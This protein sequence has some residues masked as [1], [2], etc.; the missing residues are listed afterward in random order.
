[1]PAEQASLLESTARHKEMR[2]D[3]EQKEQ[4]SQRARSERLKREAR[5]AGEQVCF[6]FSNTQGCMRKQCESGCAC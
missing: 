2:K 1:M 6:T 4:E 5:E 3:F